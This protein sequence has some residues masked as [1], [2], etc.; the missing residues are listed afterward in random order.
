MAVITSARVDTAKITVKL[1][2]T[3]SAV[4]RLS[5]VF[6]VFYNLCFFAPCFPS[7]PRSRECSPPNPGQ[8][9][10]YDQQ[11]ATTSYARDS[12]DRGQ[13]IEAIWTGGFRCCCALFRRP[14]LT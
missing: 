11:R 5:M 1:A 4:I 7:R 2:I 3:A 9:G 13:L 6:L 8:I 12:G 14:F 10:I